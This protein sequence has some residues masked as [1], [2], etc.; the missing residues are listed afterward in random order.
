LRSDL[1]TSPLATIDGSAAVPSTVDV[2]VNSSR[3]YS[4]QVGSGPFQIANLPV[5]SGP[6]TVRVVLRDALGR[7]TVSEAVYYSSPMLLAPG[8]MDYSLEAGFPR[9]SY[10]LVSN[11]Y[12]DDPFASGSIR[13]GYTDRLTLEGHT[14]LG[15]NLLNAGS[16]MAFG[17]GPLG[18]ASL[19]LAARRYDP[20]RCAGSAA[21]CGIE[22]GLQAGAGIELGLG[23]WR[24]QAR[25]LRTFGGYAD[26]ASV[27]SSENLL[28]KGYYPYL[29]APSVTIDQFSLGIPLWDYSHVNLNFTRTVDTEDEMRRIISLSHSRRAFA[30]ATFSVSGYYD[31]DDDENAGLF[32]GLHFSLSDDIHA[33]TGYAGDD[34]GS[35]F[36]ASIAKPER[37][38]IGSYGWRV[39]VQEGG[40][41]YRSAAVS[42]RTRPARLE[43]GIRQHS[44]DV[45]TH[46]QAEGAVAMLDGHAFFAN[47]IDDAFAVVDTG[48]PDIRVFHE[49]R[50][51]GVTDE[52][53]ILFVPGLRAWQ[54]NRLSIDPANFPVTAEIVNTKKTVVPRDRDRLRMS[55]HRGRIG[56]RKWR[57][58]A[59]AAHQR[60]GDSELQSVSGCFTHNSLGIRQRSHIGKSTARCSS[61]AHTGYRP[62]YADDLRAR[63]WRPDRHYSGYLS[64][65]FCRR[66]NKHSLWSAVGSRRLH[67]FANRS[68]PIDDRPIH[69]SSDG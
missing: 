1:L 5:M 10:G 64:I 42:Y 41:Q 17:L 14:E 61:R 48:K 25:T 57:N 46:A 59:D 47:R 30:N 53:G 68:R 24:V 60:D 37:S 33:S 67:G 7:E 58:T 19:S 12:S 15:A 4:N 63:V 16:G 51:I 65:E 9:R 34:D 23:D 49:N 11:D 2:F 43:A 21:G 45:E 44:G 35:S 38:E 32:A 22:T 18:I 69:G 66:G 29:Y 39:Q 20:D 27:T 55:L 50:P 54:P 28:E 8:L 6:G 40:S 13:Y 26:I 52:D 62:R 31:L 56:W 3:A 36:T